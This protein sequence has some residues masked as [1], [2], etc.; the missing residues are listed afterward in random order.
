VLKL[1]TLEVVRTIELSGHDLGKAFISPD[2]K[3]IACETAVKG[4]HRGPVVVFDVAS[5]EREYA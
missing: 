3:L 1:P 2:G 4:R 5:G